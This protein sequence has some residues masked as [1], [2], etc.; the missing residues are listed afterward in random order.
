M[1]YK[2]L[3]SEACDALEEA[4]KAAHGGEMEG[5]AGFVECVV[6]YQQECLRFLYDGF[7]N[8]RGCVL[9]AVTDADEGEVFAGDA[10]CLGVVADG[11]VLDGVFV[12]KREETAIDIILT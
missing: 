7:V 11:T 1:P 8:P 3:R 12:E 10:Q 6:V 9:F 4:A 2:F 5:F